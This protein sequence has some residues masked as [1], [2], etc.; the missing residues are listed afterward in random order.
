MGSKSV[1]PRKDE[2]D[3][4][5]SKSVGLTPAQWDDLEALRAARNRGDLSE[6]VRAC[7]SLGITAEKEALAKEQAYENSVKVSRKLDQRQGDIE[8]AV[9]ALAAELGEDHPQVK[10]LRRRLSD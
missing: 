9:D 8:Q 4:L 7:I 3:K 1:A 6:Q 2:S 10:I 5:S